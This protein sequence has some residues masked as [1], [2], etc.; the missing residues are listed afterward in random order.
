MPKRVD[1][2]AARA[3]IARAACAA[4]AD[5]GIHR[6]RMVDIAKAAGVT[7]G[8]ITNYF[9]GKDEIIATAL[10]IPFETLR[11]KIEARIEDGETDLAELLDPA[12]PSTAEQYSETA[13]WV[14]FWGLL[15]AEPKLRP[16]NAELHREGAEIFG[17][18]IRTAWPETLEMPKGAFEDLR[19]AVTTFVFGLSA[20]GVTS[21]ETWTPYVQRDQLRRYLKGLRAYSP[22]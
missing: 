2:D 6:V 16:L 11:A 15:A 21:P 14:S 5:R 19:V 10:R 8:M 18:A 9:G 7:T 22:V 12:I 3:A 20:G 4:I 17:A 13:T 1:P